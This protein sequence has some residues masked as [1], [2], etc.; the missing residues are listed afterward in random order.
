M[1]KTFLPTFALGLCVFA[2]NHKAAFAQSEGGPSVSAAP[3][4]IARA[5]GDAGVTVLGGS[6]GLHNLNYTDSDAMQFS[7]LFDPGVDYFFAQHL[8]VG[9]FGRVSYSVGKGYDY[10]GPF[11]ETKDTGYGAGARIGF[12]VEA[13]KWLSVWPKVGFGVT[14]NDTTQTVLG[15]PAGFS[16][17]TTYQRELK[18][19]AT[20]IEFSVPL[21]LHAAPH[22]F[23][24]MGPYVYSDIS[25]TSTSAT[26]QSQEHRRTG[27][28]VTFSTGGWI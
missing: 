17:I 28:G 5:F 18:T 15:A 20:W 8:S 21:L 11:I 9:G 16:S 19:N 24:G 22:F 10:F 7:I 4:P 23:V 26:G 27:I 2:S 6:I 12:N 25:R 14:H 13:S 3:Q 1:V